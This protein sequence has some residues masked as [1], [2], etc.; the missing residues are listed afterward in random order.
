LSSLVDASSIRVNVAKV[1]QLINLVG[2]L[3][4]A[5]AMVS[6]A[7]IGLDPDQQTRLA[8]GLGQLERNT[9]DLQ[10]AILAIRMLP[11]SFVFSRLPR[12]TRDLAE[13]LGKDVD[14]EMLGE[15]TELDKSVI[16]KIADPLTHRF[17]M[18]SITASRRR[19][20][21]PTASRPPAC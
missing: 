2:E 16:E 10:D 5:E 4:I 15:D 12:L 17:A 19:S 21:L 11:I 8:A 20:E 18:P 14:L 7:A 9:R 3:V 13:R 1:D 6:Q